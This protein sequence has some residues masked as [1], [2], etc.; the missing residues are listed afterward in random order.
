MCELWCAG[1]QAVITAQ[2]LGPRHTSPRSR[3]GVQVA[4]TQSDSGAGILGSEAHKT[5]MMP[6]SLDVG[7]LTTV[8]PLVSRSELNMID[9]RDNF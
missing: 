3:A 4:G 1:T 2:I 5:T 8:L 7:T 9:F 6:R